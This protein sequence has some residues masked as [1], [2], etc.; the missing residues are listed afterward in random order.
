MMFNETD[1][2]ST[3]LNKTVS[4]NESRFQLLL[5]GGLVMGSYI[6]CGRR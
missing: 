3:L 1:M 2:Y 5:N 4:V 6:H